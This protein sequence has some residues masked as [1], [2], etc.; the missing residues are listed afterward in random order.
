MKILK[1]VVVALL[2]NVMA[3][4]AAHADLV[5]HYRFTGGSLSDSTGNGGVLTGYAVD[6]TNTPTVSGSGGVFGGGYATFDGQN[7]FNTTFFPVTGN[8]DR[9][10]SLFIRTNAD[11][12]GTGGGNTRFFAGWGSPNFVDR[13]RFDLGFQADSNSQLRN[14]YNNGFTNSNATTSLNTGDWVHVAVVWEGASRT[15]TFYANQFAYGSATLPQNLATG[16]GAVQVGLTIGGDTRAAGVLTG[17]STITPNRFFTGDISDVRV[18]NRAL[19][20][21]EIAAIPE[22]STALML[23]AGLAGLAVTRRRN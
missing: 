17:A 23:V 22:P 19:T 14:E 16:N 3:V 20:A 2:V 12:S 18:Y 10:L 6:S 13:N 11:N 21:A 4:S 9:T 1:L 8:E 5:A 15:A 7:L